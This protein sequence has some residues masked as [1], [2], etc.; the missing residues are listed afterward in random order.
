[1]FQKIL[2][3]LDGSRLAARVLGPVRRLLGPG[4]QLTLLR[5][6][7]PQSEA[8][9]DRAPAVEAAIKAQLV[10]TRELLGDG[11]SIE[12]QVLRG[13]PAD[14]IA[15]YARDAGQDLVAMATHGRSGVERWVRGSVAERVLRACEVPLLLCNPFALEPRDRGPFERVLVPLDGSP[16]SARIVPLVEQV[17]RA[18]ASRVTLLRVEPM[19]ISEVPSPVVSGSLWDPAPLESSL[20][21]QRA[22]L[23]AAGVPVEARAAYGVVAAEVLRAAREAD[24]LAMTTHGRSGVSRWWFGSVA[25]Q[26]LRH[27]PCPL[28]VLRTGGPTL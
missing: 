26:V 23:A 9:H 12:A 7:E 6:V 11:A 15:R 17:A 1:M 21:P 8:E 22:A 13:D 3:P 27:A 20:E 18:H 25:E 16:T 24:L 4:A 14:E 10:Q 28:L 2:V 5:V 19:I